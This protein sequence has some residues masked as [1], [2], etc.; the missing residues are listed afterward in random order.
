[1]RSTFF[2]SVIDFTS[3]FVLRSSERISCIRLGLYRGLYVLLITNT[4][5]PIPFSLIS[6]KASFPVSR[7]SGALSHVPYVLSLSTLHSLRTELSG[8]PLVCS[9]AVSSYSS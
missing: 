1:M 9:W 5:S 2:R 8:S 6:Y 3:E 7:D 4:H